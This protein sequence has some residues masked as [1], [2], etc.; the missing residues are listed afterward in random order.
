MR[1]RLDKIKAAVAR[2]FDGED[3]PSDNPPEAAVVFVMGYRRRHWSAR[4]VRAV[5]GFC[6]REW[7]W[8]V[9]LALALAALALKAF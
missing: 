3:V 6:A 8:L 9:W 2:W 7:K 4:L 5:L 1:A